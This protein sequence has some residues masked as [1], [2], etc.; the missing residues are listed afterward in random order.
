M[1]RGGG[2]IL[3]LGCIAA[4]CCDRA[5]LLATKVEESQGHDDAREDGHAD[6]QATPESVLLLLVRWRLRTS[7]VLVELRRLLGNGNVVSHLNRHA[8][9]LLNMGR[10]VDV[11]V[12]AVFEVCNRTDTLDQ[13]LAEVVSEGSKGGTASRGAFRATVTDK[14]VAELAFSVRAA[15]EYVLVDGK[16]IRVEHILQ[17]AHPILDHVHILDG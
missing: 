8:D 14:A 17:V 5:T 6:H 16:T 7:S 13:G 12:W 11:A 2:Q 3:V 10:L 1:L 15:E 4:G 9:Q